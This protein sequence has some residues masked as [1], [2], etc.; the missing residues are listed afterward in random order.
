MHV[1]T[2]TEREAVSGPRTP[3]G[4][5]FLRWAVGHRYNS[6]VGSVMIQRSTGG[7][8][9]Y[10]TVYLDT[11][12][13]VAIGLLTRDDALSVSVAGPPLL[14]AARE[15]ARGRKKWLV[16]T[17]ARNVYTI[18]PHNVFPCRHPTSKHRQEHSQ[19]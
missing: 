8:T 6:D 17:I 5:M 16:Q 14:T 7:T 1:Y 10:K 18:S 11:V 12:S 13:G 4:E 3:S 19:P 2:S 15:T 9:V